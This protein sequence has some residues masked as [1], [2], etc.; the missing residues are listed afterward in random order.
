MS[1]RP[2]TVSIT[3]CVFIV[4]GGLSLAAALLKLF[5]QSADATGSAHLSVRDSMFVAA[6]AILAVV[7]GVFLFRRH[8]WAR[9]LCVVWMGGH[10]VISLLHSLQQSVVHG[11]FLAII[12]YFLFRAPANAYFR[13]TMPR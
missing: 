8:N 10:V 7:G 13:G 6:T 3:G 11:V 9:W 2:L 1:K 4:T 12:V 5:N